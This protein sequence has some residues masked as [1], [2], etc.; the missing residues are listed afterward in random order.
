MERVPKISVIIPVYRVERYLP[1]C[2]D[3]VLNQ[4]VRDLE[5]ILVD[6][7]SPD[8]CGEICDR[9]G[10]KDSRIRVIHKENGGLSSARNAGLDVARGEYIAFVD[11]D[12]TVTPD[13]Y[14]KMLLCAKKYDVPLVCAGR[15]NVMEDTLEVL[16][17]LCP[18]KEE[19]VSGV[20]L[21][22]RIFTWQDLDSAAWDKLCRRELFDGIRYPLGVW[23]EDMP[24][25]FRIALKAGRAALCPERVY[26]YLQREGSITNSRVSE[27][28]FHFS[29]HAEQI[30]LWIREE[31]PE[32]IPEARY[33]RVRSLI[34]N[35]RTLD[36]AQ[37]ED[38]KRFRE[39]CRSSRKALRRELG[40][41]YGCRY[42]SRREQAEG[43]LL[44]LGLY[45]GLRRGYYI[46]RGK[47]L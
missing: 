47:P 12:D 37:P 34:H 29:A 5:I 32:L 15:W 27:K 10:E 38:R 17:G 36:L 14:E 31:Y 39:R 22:R 21:T 23:N 33:L 28:T 20:E 45:R 42:A 7:G 4:T 41:L 2:L 46:V 9:Y 19:T 11:S 16:P 26:R 1:D 18:E 3:S 30:L 44:A 40:F 13:C 43:T 25:T 24:I 6:D 8:R 35:V